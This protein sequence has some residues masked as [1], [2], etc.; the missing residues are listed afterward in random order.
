MNTSQ[1]FF[2]QKKDE[3]A[4]KGRKLILRITALVLLSIAAFLVLHLVG[5]K[6]PWENNQ[7]SHKTIEIGDTFP[8]VNPEAAEGYLPGMTADEIK[9]H[10]EKPVDEEN[11]AYLINL[12]PVF[13]NGKSKGNLEIENPHYNVFPMVVQIFLTDTNEIIYDSGG[14]LPDRHIAEDTLLKTLKAGTYN[15]TAIINVYNPETKVW[16]GKAE[17]AL[18]ITIQK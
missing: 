7:N 9:E 18:V 8:K 17:E 11:V 15:A 16:Q 10:Q 1:E 12:K 6:F 2:D 13:E 5:V 14:I 4:T 3:K